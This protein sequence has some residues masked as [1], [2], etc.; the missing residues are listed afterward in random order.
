MVDELSNR[1]IDFILVIELLLQHLEQRSTKGSNEAS[2][3]IFHNLMEV[4]PDETG[5]KISYVES[6]VVIDW[7][8]VD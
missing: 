7:K 6:T 3:V 8:R 4:V 1:K 5:F 2:L